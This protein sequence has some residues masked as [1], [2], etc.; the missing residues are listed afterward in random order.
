M[1]H[2]LMVDDHPLFLQG[3]V[4]IINILLPDLTVATATNIKDAKQAIKKQMP[5]LL[6]LDLM[7]SNKQGFKNLKALVQHYPTLT[8]SIFSS[9]EDKFHIQNAM[10]FGAK[11]YIFKTLEPD[12][13]VI[14]INQLLT[15][16]CY[17]PKTIYTSEYNAINTQNKLKLTSRQMEILHLVSIGYNN[18]KISSTLFISEGTVK[19][20]LH[21]VFKILNVKN[22]QQAVYHVKHVHA[23]PAD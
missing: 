3:M 19:Q 21:K 20:H 17:F 2:L 18:K 22:R 1:K 10:Y 13:L 6:L 5:D 9:S 16:T 4:L 11:G 23:I 15:G 8:I 14:A 7:L 12:E